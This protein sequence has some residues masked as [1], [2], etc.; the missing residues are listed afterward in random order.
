M[1]FPCFLRSR[2]FITTFVCVLYAGDLPV[3]IHKVRD[4]MWIFIAWKFT[5]NELLELFAF[6]VVVA[7]DLHNEGV[8]AFDTVYQCVYHIF[9]DKGVSGQDLS[10]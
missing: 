3:C 5:L 8:A 9:M 2:R 10:R 4:H 7:K 6:E 1:G